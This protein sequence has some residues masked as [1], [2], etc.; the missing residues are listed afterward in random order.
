MKNLR[1][2][3][4]HRTTLHRILIPVTF[5]IDPVNGSRG[6]E[7]EIFTTKR[8]HSVRRAIEGSRAKWPEGDR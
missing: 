7:I 5:A 2:L 4:K 8:S 6:K 1:M 3:M